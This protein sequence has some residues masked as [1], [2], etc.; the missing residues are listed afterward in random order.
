MNKNQMSV[1]QESNQLKNTISKTHQTQLTNEIREYIQNLVS[2]GK[3]AKSIQT[4]LRNHKSY[5]MTIKDIQYF[6]N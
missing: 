4:N 2:N 5:K 1:K 6:L 3:S